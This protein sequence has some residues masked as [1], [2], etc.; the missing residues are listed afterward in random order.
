MKKLQFITVVLV[1]MAM[2]VCM[3]ISDCRP[4]GGDCRP[5]G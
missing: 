2:L 3:R 5:G 1:S 4:G